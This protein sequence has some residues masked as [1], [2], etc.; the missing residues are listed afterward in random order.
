MCPPGVSV[1]YNYVV[2]VTPEA[3][4]LDITPR[5]FRDKVQEALR[6]EGLHVGLWQ[7]L[8]V[9]AQEIFQTRI[10]YGKGCP[11]TCGHGRPVEYRKEDY[12]V[13]TAFLDSHF[14][15]FDVNPPND[16]DLMKRYVEAFEKVMDNVGKIIS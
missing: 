6:A 14:Y 11:W 12:P 8:P 16:L 10:G 4:G 2:G 1:Y 7:R 3:L 9:P 13:A 15:V 5:V